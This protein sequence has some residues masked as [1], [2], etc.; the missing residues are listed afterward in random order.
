MNTLVTER[1][2]GPGFVFA[3]DQLCMGRC[4]AVGVPTTFWL[5]LNQSSQY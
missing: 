2:L 5:L 1:A 3:A 4:A